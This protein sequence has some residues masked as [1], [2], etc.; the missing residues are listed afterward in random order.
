MSVAFCMLNP[1]PG[2]AGS[3]V[4]RKRPSPCYHKVRLMRD[5]DA[6]Q[7]N[8]KL[9]VRGDMVLRTI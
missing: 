5:T 1:E 9:N 8:G 2:T 7:T 6:S 4:S 3:M